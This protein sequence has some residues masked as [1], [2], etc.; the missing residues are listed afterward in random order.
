MSARFSHGISS[1]LYLMTMQVLT[2][3]KVIKCHEASSNFVHAQP[4]S[5]L[6]LHLLVGVEPEPEGRL[7]ILVPSKTT[8]WT[9]STFL[10]GAILAATVYV[11]PSSS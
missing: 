4:N 8:S 1:L 2:C 3:T 9:E 7:H 11:G 5:Y 10:H 6:L